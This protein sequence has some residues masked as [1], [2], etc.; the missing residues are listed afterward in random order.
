MYVFG[1]EEQI[2]FSYQ[3]DDHD[4][5]DRTLQAERPKEFTS[6]SSRIGGRT[7]KGHVFLFLDQIKREKGVW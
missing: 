5:S 1:S 7:K 2:I 6:S 4:R 3:L